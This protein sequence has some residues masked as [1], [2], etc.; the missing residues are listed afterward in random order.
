MTILTKA[1]GD[2]KKSDKIPV[3]PLI[4]SEITPTAPPEPATS[5]NAGDPESAH[6][7]IVLVRRARRMSSALTL[8]L[9][10]IALLVTCLGV[11]GGI[12]FYRQYAYERMQRMRFHC[13]IPYDSKNVNS[14]DVYFM[15][16][17]LRDNDLMQTMLDRVNNVNDDLFKPINEFEKE[18]SKDFLIN[19]KLALSQ[20]KIDPT[21]FFKEEFELDLSDDEAYEK[22]DVPEFRDG[23]SGRFL[24]DFNKNQSVI[25]DKDSK[26]CFV[27]PLDQENVLKPKS[28]ADLI[29]KMWNG[30]YTINTD[31]VRKNMRV[32]TPAVEDFSDISPI[33]SNEC[34][35]MK[36]YKLEKY[37]SGVFKRSINKVNKFAVFVGNGIIEYDIHE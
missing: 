32:V 27:M 16:A 1:F 4:N 34:S 3:L 33:I 15:N 14:N 7:N 10:L 9:F 30:Y 37:V 31:V 2:V 28:L 17:F 13:K 19:E 18:I 5:S 8:I 35:D 36:T 25:I 26:R 11:I 24:H 21:N 22:I 6:N 20:E 29:T 23:R 12:L